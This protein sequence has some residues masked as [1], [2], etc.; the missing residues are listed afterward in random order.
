MLRGKTALVTSSTQGIGL[1]TAER[2]SVDRTVRTR[3]L[4]HFNRRQ[5]WARPSIFLNTPEDCPP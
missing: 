2:S 4:R 1:A 5:V 3:Q